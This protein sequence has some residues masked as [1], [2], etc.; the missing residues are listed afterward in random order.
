[1]INSHA[2]LR[3][4]GCLRFSSISD[5]IWWISDR[6]RQMSPKSSVNVDVAVFWLHCYFW[7]I[8]RH[9]FSGYFLRKS[10]CLTVSYSLRGLPRKILG[11]V[12]DCVSNACRF[13]RCSQTSE[14]M[15]VNACKW[16]KAL[17]EDFDPKTGRYNEE[18][19]TGR[20]QGETQRGENTTGKWCKMRNVTF[21]NLKN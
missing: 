13:W 7:S 4:K 11:T 3:N 15:I 18:D 8:C 1:M 14:W 5:K 17:P 16:R 10:C 19:T 12:W 2:H 6:F 21:I 20:P 9:R